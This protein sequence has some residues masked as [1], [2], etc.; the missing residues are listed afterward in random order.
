MDKFPFSPLPTL[1]HGKGYLNN[2]FTVQRLCV[3]L[4]TTPALQRGASV[5]GVC[6][7]YHTGC[8][9]P[10]LCLGAAKATFR[11]SCI[12]CDCVYPCP[13]GYGGDSVKPCACSAGSV[14][15]YQKRISALI[16]D[17]LSATWRS[18]PYQD[19]TFTNK[20]SMIYQDTPKFG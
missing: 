18:D 11:L 1:N 15:K 6:L 16:F 17:R 5:A 7:R 10:F 8:C 13:C 19:W 14:T 9:F 20:K 12:L 2:S 3:N 4:V